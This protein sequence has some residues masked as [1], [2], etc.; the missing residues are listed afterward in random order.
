MRPILALALSLAA[1]S[2]SAAPVL[3]LGIPAPYDAGSAKT[4]A[5]MLDGYLTSALKRDVMTSVFDDNAQLANALARG[6][7]DFA[8]ITPMSYVEAS[9]QAAVVPI[10]KALRRK[11]MFYKSCL[12]VRAADAGKYAKLADLKGARAAWVEQK[13]TSG[14]VFPKGM[15]LKDGVALEGF[16]ASESFAGDHK[17]ACGAVLAGQ[18]DV[19]ATFTDSEGAGQGPVGCGDALGAAALEQLKCLAVSDNIANEVVAGRPGF[20]EALQGEIGSL[21]AS[22][23]ETEAGKKLLSTV[24]RAEGFGFALDEDFEP[25]RKVSQAVAAGKWPDNK[26]AAPQKP[27]KGGKPAPAKAAAPAKAPPAKKGK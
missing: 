7:V 10:A 8:W 17:G 27:A 9:K 19:G 2:A 12:F 16:F 22:L 6:E 18:A 4:A 14:Y 13:S 3:K 20:E 5:E 21:F 26:P 11:S 23:S 24:F 1:G 25:I 15:L